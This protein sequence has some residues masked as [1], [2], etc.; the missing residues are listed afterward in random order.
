MSSMGAL[1]RDLRTARGWSQGQ[2]ADELCRASGHPTV[3]REEI[4]RWERGVRVPGP[5]WLPHLADVLQT[6]QGVLE[7]ERLKR[8]AFLQVAALAP[9][10]GMLPVAG[11]ALGITVDDVVASVAGGDFSP[12]TELQTAHAADLAVATVSSHDR[13]SL[14]HLARWSR[15]GE[16]D[17]LR[18][19][20]AGILAKSTTDDE[21]LDGAV[22]SLI[23]DT[24]VRRRYLSAVVARVGRTRTT[25]AKEIFNPRDAGARWCA[26]YLLGRDGSPAATRTLR[27]AL[28][29]EPVRENI[30]TIGMVLNGVDPCA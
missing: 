27:R 18:V 7:N 15:D 11:D 6:P 26:A 5:F 30:R 1:I 2:L 21:L 17:V 4:S 23:N 25:L 28:A 12:L 20:A 13:A 8:R 19:N 29:A 3:T 16:S 14:L 24:A 9:I 22:A 10:A